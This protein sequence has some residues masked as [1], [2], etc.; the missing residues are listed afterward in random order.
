MGKSL[1][2]IGPAQQCG[3]QPE[4]PQGQRAFSLCGGEASGAPGEVRGTC[5]KRDEV[6][7]VRRARAQITGDTGSPAALY[8]RAPARG[9]G[10]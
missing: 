5:A 8:E 6:K 7:R 4:K 1:R 10:K 2:V 3:R 9:I